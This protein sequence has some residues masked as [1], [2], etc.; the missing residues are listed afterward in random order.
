[1]AERRVGTISSWVE[2]VDGLAVF[3]LRPEAGT[4]F[5][6]YK[7]G[8][9][10]A[11]TREGCKLTG[12][13]KDEKGVIRYE[14]LR[15]EDGTP[16]VGA[17]T[18]SYSLS[19]APFET[20][21]RGEIEIYVTLE[22]HGDGQ[23]GRF[24]ES[25]FHAHPHEG[26]TLGYVDRIVGNFTLDDRASGVEHVVMVGTGTGLAPFVGMMRQ[27]KHEARLGRILPAR[28][29]LIHAN[30][31]PLELAYDHELRVLADERIPG[32]DFAYVRSVSRPAASDAN[33]PGLCQGRANNLFRFLLG[34]PTREQEL[35]DEARGAGGETVSA[36]K[37]FERSTKPCLGPAVDGAALKMRMPRGR[38]TVLTCGNSEGMEDIKRICEKAGFKFEMEEW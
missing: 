1:V 26:D 19:S 25:L 20:K 12:R 18:H 33:D 31:T 3:R 10:I 9:Y 22:K 2:L 30:R 34:L 32:F 28:Y 35:V 37:A 21:E 27:A 38:T 17:V 29:T 24:T 36:Q 4:S 7:A 11:L 5:P 23:F 14:P 8:Q 15:N 6:P 16:K 13:V